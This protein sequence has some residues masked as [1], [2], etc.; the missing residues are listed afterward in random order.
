MQIWTFSSRR[1]F[2]RRPD[3]FSSDEDLYPDPPLVSRTDASKY[4]AGAALGQD[5]IGLLLNPRRR[6]NENTFTQ[7]PTVNS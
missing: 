1:K 3:T 4:A 6:L 7:L 2:E 5:E